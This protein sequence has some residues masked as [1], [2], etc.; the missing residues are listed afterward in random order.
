M[1]FYGF[2]DRQGRS[3]QQLEDDIRT[4]VAATTKGYDPRFCLPYIQMHEFEGLLFSDPLAFEWVQDGW[5][6]TA[7]A[8]LLAVLQAFPNPEAINDSPTTAPSKR[9]Q[10]ILGSY[11]KVEH[12]PLV[13][14]AIGIEAIRQQC[15]QFDAWLEQLQAWGN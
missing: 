4:S 14:E 5:N 13:A 8:A 15:P 3:R 9:I 2:Q 1:D 6:E 12:G 11:S 7:K 10:G